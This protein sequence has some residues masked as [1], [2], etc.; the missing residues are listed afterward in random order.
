MNPTL[1]QLEEAAK[2][3]VMTRAYGTEM[4]CGDCDECGTWTVGERRCNCGNRRIS[5][6]GSINYMK[7]DSGFTISMYI[8]TEAY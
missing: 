2:D 1:E 3:N 6:E 5:A 8:S 4:E 7:A